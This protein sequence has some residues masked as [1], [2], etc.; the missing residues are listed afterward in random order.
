MVATKRH[1]RFFI[2]YLVSISHLESIPVAFVPEDYL[3]S[4]EPHGNKSFSRGV[5]KER[6]D[7]LLPLR[8]HVLLVRDEYRELIGKIETVGEHPGSLEVDIVC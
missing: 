5:L 3:V 8:E 4:R 2:L 6:E 7:T 1:R